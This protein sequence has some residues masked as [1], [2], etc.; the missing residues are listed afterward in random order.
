MTTTFQFRKTGDKRAELII[1]DVIGGGFFGGISAKDVVMQLKDA[2]PVE[3]I[4]VRINSPGGNGF[5]AVAIYNA[6][7][8]NPARVI[9]DIDSIAG[10][11]EILIIADGD[12][13][14]AWIAADLIAQ[15]EHDTEAR[16]VLVTPSEA[17]ATAVDGELSRQL[18]D[19]PR[20][21]IAE[22]AI[23]DHG[24]AVIVETL[25]AAI[26]LA[27]RFAPEHLELQCADARTER[28]QVQ[29]LYQALT[30]AKKKSG[31]NVSGNLDSF[32]SFVQKKTEQIRKQYACDAV[33][34]T[35]EMQ[36]GQVKLK[37]KAKV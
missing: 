15:A 9:V 21:S 3:E 6:L 30:E 37:A 23:T 7:E 35:V 22:R 11:S 36:N 19:L 25:D 17:L 5:D 28:D 31:E 32:A 34:Y 24:A 10:P 29:K 13:E 1:Y 33:E 26:A 12:A 20:R 2:G 8:R 16:A 18:V 4:N 14:P 27:N